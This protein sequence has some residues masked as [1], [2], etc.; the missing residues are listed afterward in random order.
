MQTTMHLVGKRQGRSLVAAAAGR[1][2]GLLFLSDSISKRQ[3]LVDTGAEISVLPATGLDTRIRKP[4]LPLLAANGSSIKTYGKRTLSL[5]FASNKYTWNFT[6]AEVTRPLLG[7]D[8][9]RSNSLLVDLKGKRLVDA[10]MYHSTPLSLTTGTAPAP[11]PA[12]FPV[13]PTSTTGC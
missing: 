6:V 4:G 10:A 7:A 2:N 8:F 13:L 1:T 5:H 9:L 11:H 3:F 12:P